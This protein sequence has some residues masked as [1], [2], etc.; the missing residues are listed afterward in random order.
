M[1][2][3][4]GRSGLLWS[5]AL[6]LL[7]AVCAG[8]LAFNA[9]IA[10]SQEALRDAA[11]QRL[12]LLAGGLDSEIARFSYLPGMLALAPDIN[13]L[14]AAPGDTR[15]Q[16]DA[17]HYLEAFNAR[18]GTRVAYVL[19]PSGR[20]VASSNWRAPDSYF[21]ENDAFRPYFR[22]ALAGRS[23]RFFG[24]GTS[25][26]EPGYYLSS[27]LRRQGRVIG[28][29]V[30]KISLAPLESAWARNQALVWVA[31]ANRVVI[32]SSRPDWKLGTIGA[33]T[34]AQKRQHDASRQYNRLPLVPLPLVTERRLDDSARIVVWPGQGVA[35][36]YL[37][38]SHRLPG[39]SWTLGLLVSLRPVY[40]LAL[41]RAALAAVL[42][43]LSLTGLLLLNE[44]RRRIRAQLDARETLERAN[45]QLE[46]QVALRTAD[47]SAANLALQQEVQERTRAEAH[48]RQT[49]AELLQAGKLA[50]IG[51][52][53]AQLAHEINQPLA[54][55]ATLSAN[56]VKYLARGDLATAGSNLEKIAALVERMGK[57]TGA[58]R[59]FARKPDAAGGRADLGR[60]LDHA[61]FL[62][63]RRL[64]ALPAVQLH[65]PAAPAL[66]V[67]CD[68]NKL[69]QV[70]VNLL[71]NALDALADRPDGRI[72]L[73]LAA[74]D[75][76]A[77]LSVRD[78]GPGLSP[79]V[80]ARLFEP[81]FTTKPVG[82]GL[83]LVLSA[84][85]VADA[86]GTLEADNHPDGGAVFTVRLPL[87]DEEATD[88]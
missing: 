10:A 50:V 1:L 37:E 14:L 17:N 49:Q 22:E 39:G 83:G 12:A 87:A 57:I 13:A 79:E 53:S 85:I 67:R 56:T 66:T 70:L 34:P 31:D 73:D 68:P 48:L 71:G 11:R 55:L 28:V 4:L 23:S 62:L 78:T 21:G 9:S 5:V 69:E 42:T 81:F 46:H 75:G 35:P 24:V 84:Q 63:E 60:A 26:G 45:Q 20:V 15:R 29:A 86:G 43:A 47:L 40:D 6:L 88:V 51:Q 58:L 65:R 44:R 41:N 25:R 82:L 16:A 38:Q 3:R 33:L 61:L 7:P 72:A 76:M 2:K 36:R 27:A 64:A 52:M 30:V 8:W 18:A 59:A 32:L 19:D 54:A 80:R 77:T 74:A